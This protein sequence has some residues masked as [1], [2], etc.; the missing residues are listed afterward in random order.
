MK[1]EFKLMQRLKVP[2]YC[3]S[4]LWTMGLEF[5][6]L[7]CHLFFDRFYRVHEGKASEVEGNGLGLAIVNPTVEQ[8]NGHLSVE[9]EPGKGSY[10]VFAYP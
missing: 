6:H 8:H 3:Q 1:V 10:S 5:P 2:K 4:M 9:S 7:N